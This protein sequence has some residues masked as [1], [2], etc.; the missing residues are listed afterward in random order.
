[1]RS[2]AARGGAGPPGGR[3]PPRPPPGAR[4][5]AAH[6]LPGELRDT[7]S[8]WEGARKAVPAV[9]D[10]Y[11]RETPLVPRGQPI[12]KEQ[13]FLL[14]EEYRAF[15]A[16]Q[17]TVDH[18]RRAGALF[19]VISL[20]SVLIVLYVVRF[21]E[22]LA[23]SL[24]KVVG[25]C[26]LVVGTLALGLLLSR[27]PWYAVIIPLT[28]TA[29]VLTIAYNPPFALMMSL[30]LALASTT[31]LGGDLNYLLVEMSGL[32]PAVLL[33]RNVRTRTRILEVGAASG[34]AFFCMTMATGL[35]S[36]QT[37]HLMLFDAG[38]HFVW[39]TLAGFVVTGCLPL[40]ERC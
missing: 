4:E 30:S 2:P 19:L 20:L 31:A 23:R 38:R 17:T 25:V 24:P 6:R 26:A 39:G 9:I 28:V 13:L 12:T 16:N 11:P 15:Q 27:P 5:G 32:A 7:P 14:E 40:V 10:T 36:G 8:A 1:G 34:V 18:L 35:I 29:L 33:L 37:W 21:Q 3:H 22:A